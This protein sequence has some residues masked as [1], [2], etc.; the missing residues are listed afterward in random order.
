MITEV[1]GNIKGRGYPMRQSTRKS[2]R[3]FSLIELL[4]VIGI[5]TILLGLLLP[6]VQSSREAA[7]RLECQSRMGQIGRALANHAASHGVFPYVADSLAP[8]A[9][10]PPLTGEPAR[11]YSPFV[12]L[13]P[14]LESPALY[15]A[16]NFKVPA[17]G[18][19][20]RSRPEFEN[21]TVAMS[22]LSTFLCPSD[23]ASPASPWGGTNFL[24]N[25]ESTF[26][27]DRG[28]DLGA[29]P[30]WGIT[31]VAFVSNQA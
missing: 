24:Y 16:F 13:L 20:M 5:I 8:E 28:R 10:L 26:F 2:C 4:V 29:L 22:S 21:T 30:D 27:V 17:S 23:P 9:P 11:S 1:R 7:R 6:A 25:L 31:R 18:F 12:A 19:A 15:S 3:G 14:Y